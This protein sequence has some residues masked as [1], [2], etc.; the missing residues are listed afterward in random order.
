M[1]PKTAGCQGEGGQESAGRRHPHP[2]PSKGKLTGGQRGPGLGSRPSS[3]SWPAAP[4]QTQ[5][6][7]SQ[8]QACTECRSQAVVRRE[9]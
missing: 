2:H 5:A 8:S 9:P 6:Y 7:P 1:E 4:S 3:A